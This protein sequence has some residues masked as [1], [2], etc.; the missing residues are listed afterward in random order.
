MRV[1]SASLRISG[2]ENSVHKN[3]G[4]NDFSTQGSA[5]VVA[6]AHGV[7][8]STVPVVVGFLEP[9][10]QPS[11]ADCA[12]ALCYHVEQRPH[13]RHLAPEE[14]PQCHCRVDVPPCLHQIK[15]LDG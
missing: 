5:F 14:Q 3:K 13:Q 1:P 2:G 6:V 9:L 7:S 11:A 4:S 12:G 8:P 15:R 10:R